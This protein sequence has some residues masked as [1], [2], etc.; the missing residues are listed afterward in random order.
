[1]EIN[2]KNFEQEIQYFKVIVEVYADWCSACKTLAPIL[3]E[4][5]NETTQYIKICS[6]NS[7][8]NIELTH[9]L[10]VYSLPTLIF[11]K[12]G[13]EMKRTVGVKTKQEIFNIVKDI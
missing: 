13:K 7:D 9:K 8:N 3:K 2:E 11:Y 12:Y 1:M 6:I 4:L 5:E 10:K